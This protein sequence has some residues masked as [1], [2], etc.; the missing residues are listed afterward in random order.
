MSNDQFQREVA[1]AVSKLREEV[2]NLRRQIGNVS[3][4]WVHDLRRTDNAVSGAGI[5]HA[6]I[7]DMFLLE[8]IRSKGLLDG[9]DLD[10][11]EANVRARHVDNHG[12]GS[13]KKSADEA[14][15]KVRQELSGDY[16]SD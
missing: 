6:L 13:T 10:E 8:I 5:T 16:G 7:R 15:T 9:V 2:E 1:E 11:I 3:E 4:S 14:L 12:W